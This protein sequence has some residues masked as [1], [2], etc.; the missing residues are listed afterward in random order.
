MSGL[1][2]KIFGLLVSVGLIIGGLSGDMVLRGTNSS[3]ALVVAGFAFLALD[4]YKLATHG[5][6]KQEMMDSA[7][8]AERGEQLSEPAHITVTRERSV[9]GAAIAY[10]V[11]LN[12]THVGDVKN[13]KQLSFDTTAR[14]NAVVFF[15]HAGT[16]FKDKVALDIA[17]GGRA[18]IFVKAGKVLTDRTVCVDKLSTAG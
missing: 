6:T 10:R 3:T 15:D 4:I 12:G 9:L 13:G 8:A 2:G 5:R 18:E 11:Y 1:G 16:Q 7:S 17:G 14:I